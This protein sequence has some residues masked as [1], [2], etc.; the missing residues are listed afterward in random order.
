MQPPYYIADYCIC[1]GSSTGIASGMSKTTKQKIIA[2]IG[3]SASF[4]AGMPPLI[5]AV[6]QKADI[7]VVILDNRVTAMTGG[8]QTLVF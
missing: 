8:S 1:M 6:H 7:I 5:N 4:H 3:D 2:L